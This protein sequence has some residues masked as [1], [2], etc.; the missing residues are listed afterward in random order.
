[1]EVTQNYFV[2]LKHIPLFKI[3]EIENETSSFLKIYFVRIELIM[4]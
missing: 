1:M 4:I 2:V 3:H